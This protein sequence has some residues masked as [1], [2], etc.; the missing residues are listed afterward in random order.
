MA[1][2]IFDQYTTIA[3]E[4]YFFNTLNEESEGE[5]MDLQKKV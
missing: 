2:V 1:I 4:L 5:D 3:V